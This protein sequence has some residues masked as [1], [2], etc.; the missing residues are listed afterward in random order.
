[1]TVRERQGERV[2]RWRLEA[3]ARPRLTA[4]GGVDA[5]ALSIRP[6]SILNAAGEPVTPSGL[7]WRLERGGGAWSLV[8]RLDDAGLPLPYVIDPAAD[9]GPSRVYLT[10][11]VSAVLGGGTTAPRPGRPTSW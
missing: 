6:V 9:Y 4:T 11:T 1:L 3:S 5:G 7:R 8:L 10:N 2:W